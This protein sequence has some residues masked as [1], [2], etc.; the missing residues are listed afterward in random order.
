MSRWWPCRSATM[1][2]GSES[3]RPERAGGKS[4]AGNRARTCI[5]VSFGERESSRTTC[6]KEMSTAPRNN[7]GL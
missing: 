3:S 2:F 1:V 7:K 4:S 6:T 5:G